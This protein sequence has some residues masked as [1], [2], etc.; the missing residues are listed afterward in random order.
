MSPGRGFGDYGEGY[1]R[2]ALIEKEQRLKQAVRQIDRATKKYLAGA[3]S[4]PP[5]QPVEK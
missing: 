2:L 4:S 1:L 5:R 3:E